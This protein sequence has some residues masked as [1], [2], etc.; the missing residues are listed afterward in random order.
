[1]SGILLG[2]GGSEPSSLTSIFGWV[3]AIGCAATD[4]L[5]TIGVATKTKETQAL[6]W[7]RLEIV[8]AK[9][10]DTTE[11]ISSLLIRF[12]NVAAA[13]EHGRMVATE[14]KTAA[15]KTDAFR[16]KEVHLADGESEDLPQE[17]DAVEDGSDYTDGEA[18]E[19]VK[20]PTKETGEKRTVPSARKKGTRKA[21]EMDAVGDSSD[22]ADEDAKEPVKAPAK[23]TGKKRKVPLRKK[24]TRKAKVMDAV[25][26]S[27]DD[28]DEDAKEPV[29][30]PDKKTGKKRKVPSARTKAVVK[31]KEFEDE[32]EDLSREMDAVEDSSHDTVEAKEPVKT[33]V[34]KPAKKRKVSSARKKG[35][36][37][38]KEESEEDL[39]PEMDAAS[40][41]AYAESENDRT[42]Q[43]EEAKKPDKTPARRRSSRAKK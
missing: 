11:T 41:N 12:N 40:D 2:I 37:Q 33:P 14:R 34:K 39:F 36:V 18:K 20:A 9:L 8:E 28:A 43:P 4:I 16:E 15:N 3:G 30:V 1:M 31:A 32:G 7:Q 22:D 10:C 13:F 19:P 24:G 42:T 21:K 5:L 27:S 26:D 25:Q 35:A 38:A 29:K 17:M 6:L 23:E